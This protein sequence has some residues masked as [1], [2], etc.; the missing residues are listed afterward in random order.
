MA[1]SPTSRNPPSLLNP[2]GNRGLAE[3]QI[4]STRGRG[5]WSTQAIATAHEAPSGLRAGFLSEYKLFS[6]DLSVGLVEPEGRTPLSPLMGPPL[7]SERTVY[8]REPSG[9]YTPLVYPGNV[10]EG[11]EFGDEE[12]HGRGGKLAAGTGVEFAGA[13]PD[14]THVVL[15]APQSLV[16]G[17]ETEGRR[18][19]YEWA[20]GV[21]TP[22]SIFPGGA[23]AGVERGA[24][25]GYENRL[26]RNAVLG[27]W[28][29][30][31]LPGE[32][33]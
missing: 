12:E 22:V 1:R 14:L 19:L 20:G 15:W 27:G 23:S 5:G 3:Q 17:F 2:E 33:V 30:C 7:T 21:L 24:A 11:T 16:A 10:P 28:L 18:A 8:L 25:L 29:A 13:S 26:V 4:L 6:P 9:S 32:K 31:V